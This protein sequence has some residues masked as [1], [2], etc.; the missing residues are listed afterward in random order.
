MNYTKTGRK[1]N[2]MKISEND[3]RL[4]GTS[5]LERTAVD[6][7]LVLLPL[8]AAIVLGVENIPNGPVWLIATSVI[9]A[10]WSIFYVSVIVKVSIRRSRLFKAID[11]YY[12]STYGIKAV[13]YKI[14]P[15]CY[16]G[17]PEDGAS[18]TID[19]FK[20]VYSADREEFQVFEDTIQKVKDL[21]NEPN[22]KEV[23]LDK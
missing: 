9:A 12:N 20:L 8:S 5:S 22:Y 17:T 7:G 13:A 15:L 11:D 18:V 2:K 3:L 6:F 21:A 14:A 10:I 19:R 1:K 23:I 4:L 16:Y